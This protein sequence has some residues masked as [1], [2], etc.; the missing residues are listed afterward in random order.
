MRPLQ[1]AHLG[2]GVEQRDAS[3]YEHRRNG[4]FAHPDRPGQREL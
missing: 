3:L 4:R 2:V 1:R